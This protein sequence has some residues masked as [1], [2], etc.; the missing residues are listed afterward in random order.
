MLCRQF[1]TRQWLAFITIACIFLVIF[2]RP[3]LFVIDS[4]AYA[5]TSDGKQGFC[6]MFGES[7]ANSYRHL[8]WLMGFDVE[9]ESCPKN[10]DVAVAG[11][12][13]GSGIGFISSLVLHIA[14][15]VFGTDLLCRIWDWGKG[16]E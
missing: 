15:A 14:G 8:F 3:I 16:E 7:F 9:Y 6:A 11:Y 13:F 10:S 1:T 4:I 2:N 5:F 12:I